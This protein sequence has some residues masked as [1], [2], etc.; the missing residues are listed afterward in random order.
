MVI[1]QKF[2]GTSVATAEAREV[3]AERVVG[4]VKEG[5]L[6]VVVVSAMGRGG[7]PYATD[8]LIE[9]ARNVHRDTAPREMDLLISCG[10][11]ISS[12]IVANTLKKRDLDAMV[13]TGG[14]AGIITDGNF[15]NAI[16][17]RVQP[18]HLLR[19]IDEGRIVVVCGFQGVTENGDVTTLGR[20]G[21]DTTA[22]A[23]GAAVE[24]AVVD[25]Y[26]D[27]DGIKTADPKMVP[28]ARTIE[29]MT[30]EEVAQI[31][32]QGAKVIHPRAVEICRRAS[33][34]LRIRSTF[35]ESPG[36]LVAG[37]V[38]PGR[39]WPEIAAARPVTAI[40]H[41]CPVA[42][43]KVP[44]TTG[45]DGAGA[46]GRRLFRALAEAGI[47]VDMITVT[48]EMNCFIVPEAVAERASAVVSSIGLEPG[49]KRGCGKVS[50]VG[51]GMTGRPGVMADVS[52]ALA[53]AGIPI[54]QTCD[55]NTTISCLIPAAG[56]AAAM[57]SLHEKFSL[58]GNNR[59]LAG[60]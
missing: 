29:R 21:S 52:D 7:D 24:A 3:V 31:A 15:N 49:L 5:Y 12:V 42:Q 46:G 44:A 13:L 33:I 36:T 25:I 37:A 9:L 35:S 14:Q 1:V 19:H 57:R 40:A 22:A 8:T 55:S 47:S 4:A 43:F 30:Y 50:V 59:C 2:G 53:G 23:L 48:P 16:I 39:K 20:G 11:I 54:L 45:E 34:P 17:L 6:P 32:V 51:H 26:T 38:E 58:G 56:I 41:L 10:E 27:V 60:S 18:D 28:E